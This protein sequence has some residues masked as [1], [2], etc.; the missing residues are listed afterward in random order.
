MTRVVHAFCLGAALAAV[1]A[2]SAWG[3]S[4]KAGAEPG[5]A[6]LQNLSNGDG[7]VS[8]FYRYEDPIPPTPG[9]MLREETLPASQVLGNAETGRRILYSSI[10]GIDDKTLVIVSGDFFMP[11]GAPP[12]GGWPLIAWAH[13][14]DGQADVCAPSWRGR[15]PR[16]IAYLNAWLAQGYAVV[17]TDYQGLGTPGVHTR[18]VARAEAYSVLDGIRAVL[19]AHPELARAVVIVGQSQGAHA[20]VS[21]LAYKSAYAPDIPLRATVLTGVRNLPVGPPGQLSASV[22]AIEGGPGGADLRHDFLALRILQR[23]DGS[24]VPANYLTPLGIALLHLTSATCWA[25]QR[26]MFRSFPATR[27]Q[28][29][30]QSPE[31]AYAPLAALFGVPTLEFD[32]PLFIGTGTRD[33][34]VPP[35]SQY[36]FAKAACAAGV[37]VEHRYYAGKNHNTAVNASLAD[38]IPFVKK[39][40]AGSPIASGCSAL[41]P[42][43]IPKAGR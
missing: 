2:G 20:S 18:H 39:A 34:T 37:A 17:S 15:S 28:V 36:A 35:A 4:S 27:S 19:S 22:R 7:G 12:P 26:V 11:R 6:I 24:F 40:F 10:D 43:P 16:D 14:T 42:P 21:A 29:F 41:S 31:Q 38:S 8:S 9:R 13:G 5:G 3:Q 1:A 33:G 30:I 25:E 23:L 32:R